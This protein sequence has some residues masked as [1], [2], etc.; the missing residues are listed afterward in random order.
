MRKEADESEMKQASNNIGPRIIIATILAII[1]IGG[2]GG[3]AMTAQL[4]GAVIASGKVIVD[5]QI[6]AVQHP[7]GGIVSAIRIREGDHVV[8][9]QVIL[10]LEETQTQAELSIIEAQLLELAVRRARLVAERD[11]SDT[12]EF[13]LE[14][15][16]SLPVIN[17]LVKGEQRLFEGHKSHRESRKRQLELVISQVKDEISGLEA[18]LRSKDDETVLVEEHRTRLEYLVA[19]KL[20]EHTPLYAVKREVARLSGERGE[21]AA[22]IARARTKVNEISL[23]ILDID[24]NARTEAQRELTALD[25]KLSELTDRQLAVSDRLSRTEIRSPISGTIHELNIHTVGGVIVP[26]EVLTTIVPVNAHLAIEIMLPPTS[27]DQVEVG[28]FARVRLPALNQRTTPE[29][30]GK[31]TYVSPA[32]TLDQATGQYF[33]RAEIA[34]E[35]GEMVKLGESRLIPG[36]PVEAYVTTSERTAMS[37]LIKPIT[38]QLGKAFRER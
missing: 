5:Q 24:E 31:I 16:L 18:Q 23:Q 20:M 38:D 26:A 15:D 33:Y 22:S 2:L 21:V 9:G 14:L 1:L 19:Q 7:D 30:D 11:Q 34:L 8:E 35:D 4:S 6:K 17:A 29:L 10:R 32:T 3:W 25:A 12:I 13:P 27:I 28:S 36:M 37:Y